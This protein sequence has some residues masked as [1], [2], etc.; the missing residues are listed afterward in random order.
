MF[1]AALPQTRRLETAAGPLLLCHGVADN[2]MKKLGPDD[3]GYELACNDELQALLASREFA[4]V[5]GGH[6]HRRMARRFAD[7][8]VLNAGTL[9][10]GDAPCALLVDFAERK[11]SFYD[12]HR[13]EAKLD[14]VIDLA[15]LASHAA[16]S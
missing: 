11:A 7:L 4:F 12:V 6:T 5:V 10:R 14:E 16:P 2:D 3:F 15:A 13:H 8:V 9:R 1:L